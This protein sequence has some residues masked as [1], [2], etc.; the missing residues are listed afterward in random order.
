MYLTT[1]VPT[2]PVSG[3][4]FAFTVPG[5]QAWRVRSIVATVTRAAGGSP[6]RTYTL[7]VT[8]GTTTV[9][10]VPADDLG[11]EPGTETITWADAPANDVT[12]G[13]LSYV[14]APMSLP[15]L[16]PGYKLTGTIVGAVAGD[17]W[18]TVVCWFDFIYTDL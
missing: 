18:L 11:T 14:V 16:Y 8:D 9:A 2:A 13:A 7:T 15:A 4:S 1:A 17:T 12:S 3:T 6:N 5:Q 10:V